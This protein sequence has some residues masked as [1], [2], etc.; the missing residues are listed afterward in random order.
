MVLKEEISIVKE[1]NS[2][3]IQAIKKFFDSKKDISLTEIL[4][5]G[6][7]VNLYINTIIDSDAKVL[8]DKRFY[9]IKEINKIKQDLIDS[10]IE[11]NFSIVNI[12]IKRYELL[13]DSENISYILTLLYSN[14]QI[15][16]YV[17]GQIANKNK[18]K[19]M[20]ESISIKKKVK[21]SIKI[22]KQDIVRT[23]INLQEA[24]SKKKDPIVNPNLPKPTANKLEK[25]IRDYKEISIYLDEKEEE[26]QKELKSKIEKNIKL[27]NTITEIMESFHIEKYEIDGIIAKYKGSFDSNNTKYKEAFIQLVSKLTDEYKLIADQIL[28]NNTNKKTTPPSLKIESKQISSIKESVSSFLSKILNLF[29]NSTNKL[30]TYKDKL[31]QLINK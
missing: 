30:R 24:V 25:A 18:R 4:E 16:D 8:D 27:E 17:T 15:K 19:E 29:K 13:K 5:N 21:P 28:T 22:T 11:Q 9:M 12:A 20:F 23:L 10:L 31:K 2:L 26:L 7:F 14:N 6:N 1:T 3:I